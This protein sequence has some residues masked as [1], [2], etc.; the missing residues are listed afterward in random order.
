M[1][2]SASSAVVVL[3][4]MA[5]WTCVLRRRS[6]RAKTMA[7]MTRAGARA[8]MTSSSVGLSRN[9]MTMAPTRL[10]SDESSDVSVWVS[11]VRTCVTSLERREMSSPT[12]RRT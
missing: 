4:A 12:R 3:A 2:L 10:S 5:S 8:R 9:R 1:P 7:T 6:G 11:I